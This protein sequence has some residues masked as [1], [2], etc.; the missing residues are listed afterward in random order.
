M[1]PK[2]S[3]GRF[4]N[5][6]PALVLLAAV[7]CVPIAD[8]PRPPVVSIGELAAKPGDRLGRE[9]VVTGEWMTSGPTEKGYMAVQ[10]RDLKGGYVACHFED[11]AAAD[12]VS[13]ETQLPLIGDVTICGRYDGVEGGRAV[14]RACRLLD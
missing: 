7:G 6:F 11:V 1:L 3:L 13:L 9:V 8:P 14:L 5:G 10:L 2:T 12:R 4:R